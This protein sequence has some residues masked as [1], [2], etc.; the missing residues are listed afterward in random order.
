MYSFETGCF[1]KP[2]I[3]GGAF[4]TTIRDTS[5][6]LDG[7]V[8]CPLK[9]IVSRNSFFQINRDLYKSLLGGIS[10]K[11]SLFMGDILGYCFAMLGAILNSNKDGPSAIKLFR[12]HSTTVEGH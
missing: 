12:F 3:S 9:R 2:S 8:E 10:Q 1:M 11:S 5:L 4:C 7:Y 6:K